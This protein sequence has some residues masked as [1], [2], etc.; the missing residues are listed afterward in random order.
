MALTV[1]NQTTGAISAGVQNIV[2][3]YENNSRLSGTRKT[4]VE[5]TTKEQQLAVSSGELRNILSDEEKKVLHEVFGDDK[6]IV[7]GISF[8]AKNDPAVMIGSKLDIRL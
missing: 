5:N 1:N 6:L 3:S 7:Q 2:R 4:R 8:I